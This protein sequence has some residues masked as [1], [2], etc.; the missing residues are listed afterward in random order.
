MQLSQL[1]LRIISWYDGLSHGAFVLEK[2]H[3]LKTNET[4][5]EDL[6]ALGTEYSVLVYLAQQGVTAFV[7]SQFRLHKVINAY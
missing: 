1:N 4:M 5:I 7:T 3:S 2:L 6:Q